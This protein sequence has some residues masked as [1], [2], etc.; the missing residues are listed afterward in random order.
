M[1]D[2]ILSGSVET[3]SLLTTCPKYLISFLNKSHLEGF[4]FKLA[5]LNLLKTALESVNM[6][7]WC[8][9]EDNNVIQIDYTPV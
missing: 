1:T 3:P 5:A 7:L 6:L 8:L 9:A 4:N 2:L